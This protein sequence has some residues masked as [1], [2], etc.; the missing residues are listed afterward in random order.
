MTSTRLNKELREENER[1]WQEIDF[2]RTELQ[3]DSLL[4]RAI[5]FQHDGKLDILDRSFLAIGP[6]DAVE[7]WHDINNRCWKYRLVT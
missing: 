6:T 7:S 5:L 2:L 3:S 4:I 1:L